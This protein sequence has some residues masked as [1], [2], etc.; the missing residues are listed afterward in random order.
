MRIGGAGLATGD[1]GGG[2]TRG[3]GIAAFAKMLDICCKS[4][5]LTSAISASGLAGDGFS[6]ALVRSCPAAIA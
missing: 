6:N 3:G 4:Y 5:R 2:C 1:P